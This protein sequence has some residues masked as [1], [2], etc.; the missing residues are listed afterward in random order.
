MDAP[1]AA[2]LSAEMS[3]RL[4]EQLGGDVAAAVALPR[5]LVWLRSRF[6]RHGR[7]EVAYDEVTRAAV[8]KRAE[9]ELYARR[10]RDETARDKRADADDLLEGYFGA[11]YDAGAEDRGAGGSDG[12]HG[13]PGAASADVLRS[14][15]SLAYRRTLRPPPER[16]GGAE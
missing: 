16:Y 14:P 6:L 4:Y 12:A 9:Y 8:L 2:D 7:E 11:D 10:E 13:A 1:T 3:P 5:A 15:L